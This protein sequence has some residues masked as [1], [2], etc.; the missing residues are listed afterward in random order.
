MTF[1]EVE[2]RRASRGSKVLG[3]GCAVLAILGSFW[4][5]VW[6][7]RAYVEA[8]RVNIPAPMQLAS[9]E[10]VPVPAPAPR[11]AQ[12]PKTVE[13]KLVEAKPAEAKPA[14]APMPA[15]T[16]EPEPPTASITAQAAPAPPAIVPATPVPAAPM[17]APRNSDASPAGAI[18]DR[19]FAGNQ[20]GIITN[21]AP[22]PAAPAAPP[23]APL[24]MQP[25]NSAPAALATHGDAEPIEE[26][27]EGSVPAIAGPAPLPRRKPVMTASASKRNDATPPL[28]RPRPDGPAPQSVWTG[29]PSSDERFGSQ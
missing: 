24:D 25:A 18:A 29:V 28:P 9:R 7:I 13:A 4:G 27:E 16:P 11:P 23:P 12:V 10:S 22:A 20:F 15:A 14:E 2:V 1:D 21:T 19:W 26:V 17:A 6:F 5:I 8:P 3:F